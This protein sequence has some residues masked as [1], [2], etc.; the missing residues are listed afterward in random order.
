VKLKEWNQRYASGDAAFDQ[1]APLVAEIAAGLTPARALDVACGAGRN[2]I[3]LARLGW[4]VRAVD[5][6]AAALETLRS[7][8]GALPIESE[9]VDLQRDALAIET[10]AYQL[11]VVSYYL[12]RDLFPA[13]KRS[14]SKGGVLIAIVHMGEPATPRRAAAGEL[15]SW[16][17]GWEI[18]HYYEGG[19]RED[20]HK[21]PVAQIAARK[22]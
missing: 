5:G 3:H 10:S 22:T 2:A 13:L 8:A 1:A 6:S 20:C 21:Q 11:I 15:R 18:L 4:Q 9:L 16:F 7:R 12:Q 17:E 14:L 19:P